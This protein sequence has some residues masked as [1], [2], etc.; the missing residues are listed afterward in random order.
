MKNEND[1]DLIIWN[2]WN[3]TK[4][5]DYKISMGRNNIKKGTSSDYSIKVSLIAAFNTIF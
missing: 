5:K 2:A 4:N 3:S 1:L